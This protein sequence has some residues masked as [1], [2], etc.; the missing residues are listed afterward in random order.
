MRG[1]EIMTRSN[2]LAV[3][4]G[5]FYGYLLARFGIRGVLD[6]KRPWL[7]LALAVAVAAGLVSG[8]RSFLVLFGLVFA[9]LFF[10]E[11]LHRTRYAPVLFGMVVLAGVLVLPQ[12]DKL[13]LGV[14][15]TL[16]FLPGKFDYVATAS[17]ATTAEWRVEMWRQLLPEVPKCLFRGRGWSMDAR[18]FFTAVEVGDPSDLLAGVK[19]VG[20]FHNGPL[21]VLIPFGLYGAVAFIWFLVAGLRLLYR[22]WQLGSPELQC[23]NALLLAAFAAHTLFFLGVYGSLESDM[24]GF[25]GVLGLSVALNGPSKVPEP[26]EATDVAVEVQTEYIK[27]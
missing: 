23:V 27:A 26:A 2:E 22:N 19:L 4:G 25:V 12:A 10:V 17:A 13:P 5:A 16:S 18:D 11:G 8:Y 20:N 7:V 14:Q 24:M 1:A 3:A 21:S 6:L 9:V 15:R